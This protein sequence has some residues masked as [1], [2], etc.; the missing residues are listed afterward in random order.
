MSE[1]TIHLGVLVA[2]GARWGARGETGALRSRLQRGE[3]MK[4]KTTLAAV[5]V[6]GS[7][8]ALMFG[9]TAVSTAFTSDSRAPS[10]RRPPR[11]P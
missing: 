3:V 10:P 11:S 6:T 5:A 4:L 7:A 1:A 9:G 8:A 2:T